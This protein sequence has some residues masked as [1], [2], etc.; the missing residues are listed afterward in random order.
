MA[1]GQSG[2][3]TA[4]ISDEAVRRAT[5]RTW[6]EW[7]AALDR[8]GAKKLDHK[9]I[10]AIVEGRFGVGPWWGQMVTVGY[11]QRRGLRA[12]H[13]TPAGFQ[14]SGS[15]TLPVPLSA[16]YGAWTRAARRRE[17]LEDDGIMIRKATRNKSLRVTW[18]DGR[19][20]VEVNFYAKGRGKGQV[21]VQHRKLSSAKEAARMKRYWRR[22][23]DRL[24]AMLTG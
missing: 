3:R 6:P 22:Q 19:T 13:E 2:K 12:A 20:S 8:A 4:G 17:W 14:V 9:G 18:V 11:E 24:E 10:V 21:A 1:R 23:L 7:C 16:I 15:R 5:G